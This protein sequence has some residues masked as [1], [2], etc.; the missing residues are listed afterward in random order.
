[1]P[2]ER[3]GN[4]ENMRQLR[5][6]VHNATRMDG[7]MEKLA[8]SLQTG[9]PIVSASSAKKTDPSNPGV[10]TEPEP[11]HLN[12]DS[13]ANSL[14]GI[15]KG[16]KSAGQLYI[17]SPFEKVASTRPVQSQSQAPTDFGDLNG[18]IY[19]ILTFPFSADSKARESEIQ[20]LQASVSNQQSM[21][22]VGRIV[23]NTRKSVQGASDFFV[24]DDGGV[25][26]EFSILGHKYSMKVL[27]SFL[28]N[29]SLYPTVEGDKVIGLVMR[30]E[31]GQLV[32]ASKDFKITISEGWKKK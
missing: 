26:M 23:G 15:T 11:E 8:Q 1:M 31:N 20:K 3:S 25:R 32:N 24:G 14:S 16:T 21:L 4:G 12:V 9:Q 7:A 13:L 28:G 30:H 6:D 5:E 29:E 18:L 22:K 2:K 17:D 27:G 19:G 10:G